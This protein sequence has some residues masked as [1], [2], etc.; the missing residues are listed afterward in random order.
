MRTQSDVQ[1]ELDRNIQQQHVTIISTKISDRRVVRAI[2]GM[3]Q[4]SIYDKAAAVSKVA[5]IIRILVNHGEFSQHMNQEGIHI[6]TLKMA[7]DHL[8]PGLDIQQFGFSKYPQFIDY[9]C[10]TSGCA[11]LHFKKPADFRISKKVAPFPGYIKFDSNYVPP[12]VTNS[13][14][15][16]TAKK[17]VQNN[18]NART[19][20]P[21][22]PPP[23]PSANRCKFCGSRAMAGS[24]VCYSCQ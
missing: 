22:P 8:V 14:N 17:T 5:D 1:N 24:D 21:P 13:S 10:K 12:T 11:F 19:Y 23:K 2:S 20:I 6:T 4:I 3:K 16:Q 15:H 7:V 9:V 18:A